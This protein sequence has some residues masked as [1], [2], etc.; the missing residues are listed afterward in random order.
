MLH[1]IPDYKDPFG[2]QPYFPQASFIQK[3]WWKE[4]RVF[5]KRKEIPDLSTKRLILVYTL[6]RNGHE[7][8]PFTSDFL[9][10]EHARAKYVRNK[11]SGKIG[12]H[13]D[14]PPVIHFIFE[15]SL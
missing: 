10:K 7:V 9:Q 2:R 8:S 15:P 4:T 11:D 12:W 6:L 1:L 14:A 13:L 3:Y 5:E